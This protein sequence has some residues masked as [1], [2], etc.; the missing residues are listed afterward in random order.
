MKECTREDVY[1]GENTHTYMFLPSLPPVLRQTTMTYLG[2]STEISR[3]AFHAGHHE[4][5]PAKG[6]FKLFTSHTDQYDGAIRSA[7]LLLTTAAEHTKAALL[8]LL[9]GRWD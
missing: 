9:L 4:G 6:K 2:K 1:V 8:G 7:V 3:Q 5:Q